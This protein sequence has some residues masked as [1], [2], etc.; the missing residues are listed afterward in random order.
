MTQV[1]ILNKSGEATTKADISPELA[2]QEIKSHLIHETVV[3]ELAARRA[4]THSTKTRGQVRGGG[5]KPW[6]QKGTGRA[7][8]GSSRSPLWTGGG[9]VFGPSPRSY[10]GKVNRKVR[11]QAFLGALRAHVERRTLAVMDPT[12]WDEPSTKR[13][14]EYLRAAPERIGERPLLVCLADVDSID[15]RSFRNLDGVDLLPA[16][17]LETADLLAY[18]AVL[19]E[20]E[21]WERVAGELGESKKATAKDSG[22]SAGDAADEAWKAGTRERAARAEAQAEYATAR[23][24]EKEEQE[25]V[26]TAAAAAVA[27]LTEA[28]AS[29]SAEPNADEDAG[30]DDDESEADVAQE[31]ADGAE[32]STVDAADSED[33]GPA[34]DS[35]DDEDEDEPEAAAD[36]ESDA[37]HEDEETVADDSEEDAVEISDEELEAEA[38]AAADESD[39]QLAEE[40]NAEEESEGEEPS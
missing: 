23:R 2:E 21:A 37:S 9:I 26:A 27:A 31:S 34:E 29:V 12:G 18:R 3:A 8:A 40:A 36:D 38:L 25:A 17:Q 19:V 10:G 4:G 13:A 22:P 39:D 30:A 32:E 33:A 1:M 20:R 24:A 5:S 7:R 14:A 11:R 28:A 15:G 16:S 35:A 6:R